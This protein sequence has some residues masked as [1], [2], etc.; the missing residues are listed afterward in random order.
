MLTALLWLFFCSHSSPQGTHKAK[1][2]ILWAGIYFSQGFVKEGK[3]KIAFNLTIFSMDVLP[4]LVTE[5]NEQENK[6]SQD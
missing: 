6:G 1:N 3:E 5:N 2:V 4:S